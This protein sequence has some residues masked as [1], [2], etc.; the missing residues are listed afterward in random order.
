MEACLGPASLSALQVR[1]LL[2]VISAG[3]GEESP[4]WSA[5]NSQSIVRAAHQRGA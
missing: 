3:G 4:G 5:A 2:S 1:E